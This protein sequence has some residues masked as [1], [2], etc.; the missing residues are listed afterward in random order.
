MKKTFLAG[1]LTILFVSASYAQVKVGVT[2]GLNASRLE[3]SGDNAAKSDYKAGFQVGLSTDFGI[4][5]NFSIMPEL[6]FSQ[7]GGKS[8]STE[9]DVNGKPISSSTS[10]TI[11]Y[12]QLPVNA[13]CKF[14]VGNGS[15]LFVFAGPYLGYGL[16]GKGKSN[17]KSEG[18]KVNLSE[19]VKFGSKETEMKRIDVGVNAG[20]VYQYENVFF[21]VQYN[22]GL[23]DID[24]V[25]KSSTKNSNFSVSAGYYFL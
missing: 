3:N 21:K 16:S 15:K 10:L 4:T 14:D 2:A 19:T 11:N 5:N 7:R 23:T 18:T 24:N 13:A 12:L 1:I 22:H 17:I 20:I 6:L 25:K 9:R 8:N